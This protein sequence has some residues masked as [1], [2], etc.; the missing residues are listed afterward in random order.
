VL[1]MLVESDF[2]KAKN[3]LGLILAAVFLCAALVGI[4][5]V[6]G[7]KSQEKE[8]AASEAKIVFTTNWFAQAE[9]G[10]FFQAVEE[11]L[12][13]KEGLDV[14]IR[15]GNAQ[16]NGPILLM[17]GGTDFFMGSGF[18]AVRAVS[19]DIPIVTVA[20]IFQKDPQV[21]ISHSGVG[22][23]SLESMKG[24]PILVS[25]TANTS[26][27]PFLA[28]RYGYTDEQKR[29]YTFNI[30]P[31]LADPQAI[32]Q[33][34]GTSEPFTIE[35]QLGKKPNVIYLADHGYLPY[36]TTI[37]TRSELVEKNPELV[38]KFVTASIAGWKSYLANPQP[39]F[40]AIKRINP[41]MK[42][43]L[44]LFGFNQ[45]KEMGLVESGDALR[46]GIGAMT[47]ERWKA[48]HNSLVEGKLFPAELPIERAYT[49]KFLSQASKQP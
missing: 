43:D 38:Q 23:D 6:I 47:P 46:L 34:Y 22:N 42:D 35:K 15:Q 9:Q 20:A 25:A 29:P 11:G 13:K 26:F 2:N 40:A 37:E 45:M 31:F 8:P 3:K 5:L 33:G 21:L 16:V 39:A 44:L 14:E 7:K 4:A 28:A 48:F 36:A 49:L 24:K 17:S 30:A 19:Q 32:Q 10:G 27:W 1:I 18:E 12:Y 41:E